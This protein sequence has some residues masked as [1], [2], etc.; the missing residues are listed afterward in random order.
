MK[1]V[2]FVDDD[3]GFLLSLLDM[4]NDAETKEPFA[5]ITANNGKEAIKTLKSQPVDLVVT[6]IKMPEVD[7]FDLVAHISKE[8]YDIPV[9]VMTA[10]GTPEMENSLLDM[11]AF[12]YIEKPIDFNMLIKKISDGLNAGSKGYIVGI[13]LP[14]FMQLIQL[15]KKTCTLT[16][17]SQ[18]KTGK[19]FFQQGELT[20]AITG[21]L[22][23]QD[24]AMEI[25][26][27]DQTKIEIISICKD[28]KREINVPLGFILIES[29]RLKDERQEKELAAPEKDSAQEPQ[30]TISKEEEAI[31]S[32]DFDVKHSDAAGEEKQE[33][34]EGTTEESLPS[35]ISLEPGAEISD[36]DQLITFL[37]SAAGIRKMI[38]ISNDGKVLSK[39]NIIV[40]RFGNFVAYAAAATDQLGVGLGLTEP[41]HIIMNQNTERQL[42]IL[43]GSHITVGIE[44]KNN[45]SPEPFSDKLLKA[46]QDISC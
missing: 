24:A 39:K 40:K 10:Y 6:D 8:H 7:G 12:Q 44:L 19:L 34:V 25:C 42:L 22:V 14:S 41:Q 33:T 3:Q 29:A 30:D 43:P 46:V 31:D 4:I 2:L 1:N 35:E 27:W 9:I 23:G 26:C 38:I 17:E 28:R 32:L 20:N 21:D 15:E 11:G 36:L 45:V 37:Q 16:V 13:S 18:G 5:I